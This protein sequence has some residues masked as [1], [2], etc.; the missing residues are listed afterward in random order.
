MSKLREKGITLVA[1]VVTIIILLILAGVTL[2][3]ALGQNGLFNR[4][5]NTVDRYK[6]A[7]TDEEGMIKNLFAKI[8]SG[9]NSGNDKEES[10]IKVELKVK[11]AEVTGESI[12][13]EAVVTDE[14]GTEVKE[15]ITYKWYKQEEGSETETEGA[16]NSSH[17]FNSLDETKD[18]TLKVDAKLNSGKEVT[19][20]VTVLGFEVVD[21]FYRGTEGMTWNEWI[22]SSYKKSFPLNEDHYYQFLEL[23]GYEDTAVSRL[24][25]RGPKPYDPDH[26][27]SDF[28][29]Y[30]SV[31]RD[32]VFMSAGSG[33]S[34]G[35][36]QENFRDTLCF[37]SELDD[38]SIIPDS[39]LDHLRLVN[40]YNTR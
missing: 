14:N 17:I 29:S 7:Q 31:I 39:P 6:K 25:F 11:E 35:A 4:A 5:Q 34:D 22:N 20:E 18:Y 9:N 10:K 36:W 26:V 15:G 3:M 1:L 38:L 30:E 24:H 40:W 2:N 16:N 28:C 12:P 37:Y 23:C 13:V 21:E 33:T 8:E 32:G 27:Y 19:D